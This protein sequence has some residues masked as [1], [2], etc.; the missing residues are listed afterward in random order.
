MALNITLKIKI[1]FL[2]VIFIASLLF[3]EIFSRVL[4]FATKTVAQPN[5]RAAIIKE[6]GYVRLKPNFSHHN[7][8]TGER[9]AINSLGFRG[10]EIREKD[11]DGRKH[12]LRIVALGGSTT[13]GIGASGNANTY[14]ALLEK[15]LN[16]DKVSSKFK[17][18]DF[19]VINGG[20]P[21]ARSSNLLRFFSEKVLPLKPDAL[22]I[23]SGWN[24]WNHFYGEGNLMF[25]YQSFAYRAQ[26][27]LTD[28]SVLYSKMRNIF[29]GFRAQAKG[30]EYTQRA[31]KVLRQG[32]FEKSLDENIGKLLDLCQANKIQ[33]FLLLHPPPLSFFRITDEEKFL[34]NDP[35]FLES[36]EVMPKVHRAI[37]KIIRDTAKKK[38]VPLIDIDTEFDPRE[39]GDPL[40]TDIIHFTDAGNTRIAR[41]ISD[42]LLKSEKMRM[43][44]TTG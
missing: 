26:M 43:N 6:K 25:E 39:F 29:T 4:L 1:V 12:K 16:K 19:E 35:V 28:H 23:Y 41:G 15:F 8:K 38:Q 17:K 37:K 5:E 44:E 42:W 40:F 21:G 27:W 20:I 22:I 24:D 32:Y 10:G 30:Q 36:L 7:E 3:L 34:K 18:Y 31:K 9:F 13:F 14:P 11:G 2:I 33:A